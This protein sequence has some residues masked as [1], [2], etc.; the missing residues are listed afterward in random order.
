MKR[1]R[2]ENSVNWGECKKLWDVEDPIEVKCDGEPITQ[3]S[4]DP[5]YFL[6]TTTT[7]YIDFLGVEN[8]DFV[9]NSFLIEVVNKLKA[10]E[11]KFYA[12]IPKGYKFQSWIK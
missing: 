12:T 3:N 7:Q 6:K 9:F 5:I 11:K 1:Q 10:N 8:F 2:E 4:Q